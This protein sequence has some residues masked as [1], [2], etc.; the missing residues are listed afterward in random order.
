[1]TNKEAKKTFLIVGAF[2]V[3][4]SVIFSLIYGLMGSYAWREAFRAG[5]IFLGGLW[6][7][8]GLVFVV[9]VL[10]IFGLKQSHHYV[11]RCYAQPNTD[12]ATRWRAKLFF[13]SYLT[14][15]ASAVAAGVSLFGTTLAQEGLRRGNN[16][17]FWGGFV[18]LLGYGLLV[19]VILS[20]FS[21]VSM[22]RSEKRRVGTTVI[23]VSLMVGSIAVL[24]V[25][26]VRALLSSL[27]GVVA[28]FIV[29][30]LLPQSQGQRK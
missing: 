24:L 5:A 3:L 1:M 10:P 18:L 26:G 9:I 30:I 6:G 27:V 23:C 22:P 16:N 13:S 25:F 12:D 2:T 29:W 20:A 7:L 28:A 19:G 11:R 21:D 8:A 14:L 15:I 4:L 17:L